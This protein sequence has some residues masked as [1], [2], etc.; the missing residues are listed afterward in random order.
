ME[1]DISLEHKE[2]LQDWRILSYNSWIRVSKSLIPH[3]VSIM[4]SIFIPWIFTG[5]WSRKT[6]HW[7]GRFWL[8]TCCDAIRTLLAQLKLV[9]TTINYSFKKCLLGCLSLTQQELIWNSKKTLLSVQNWDTEMRFLV[10]WGTWRRFWRCK[11]RELEWEK[12]VSK[13]FVQCER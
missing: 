2:I 7:L 12:K 11:V 9:K 8:R 4:N 5:N 1:F 13:K 10:V 3:I 6:K